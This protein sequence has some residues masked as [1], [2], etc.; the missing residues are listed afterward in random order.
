M[1]PRGNFCFSCFNYNLVTLAACI[2]RAPSVKSY[3]TAWPSSR[4]LKPSPL[5]AEISPRN[6]IRGD[7]LCNKKFPQNFVLL[8]KPYLAGFFLLL[9][10]K[11]NGD[12]FKIHPH[13]FTLP[14]AVFSYIFLYF[15][16][17]PPLNLH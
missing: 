5:I 16:L 1:I 7:F 2:P 15:I 4:D 9:L 14:Q 17:I 10:Y 6:H 12:R 13:N 8:K 3:V 11:Q